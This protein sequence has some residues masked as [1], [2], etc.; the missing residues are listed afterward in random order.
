M[1]ATSRSLISS[2]EEKPIAAASHPYKGATPTKSLTYR[3]DH[4]TRITTAEARHKTTISSILTHLLDVHQAGIKD[5]LYRLHRIKGVYLRWM[6][7]EE[8][9]VENWRVGSMNVQV[10]EGQ[11][12]CAVHGAW[13]VRI[14]L[15]L[16]HLGVGG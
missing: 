16:K 11:R 7:G 5:P 15:S 1:I 8:T 10:T 4:V 14:L 6:L 9:D 3:P 12:L 13:R 2:T